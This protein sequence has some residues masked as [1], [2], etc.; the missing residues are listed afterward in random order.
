M[1]S[2]SDLIG[3]LETNLKSAS[4]L[5]RATVTTSLKFATTR[6]SDT[7]G[8]NLILDEFLGTLSDQDI[9]VKKSSLISLNALVHNLP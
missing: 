6:A 1:A 8:I 3:P 4:P 5:T 9:N 7:E 2:Y